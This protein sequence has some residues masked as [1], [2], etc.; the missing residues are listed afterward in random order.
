MHPQTQLQM[1]PQPKKQ[2]QIMQ[3]ELKTATQPQAMKTPSTLASMATTRVAKVET[4]TG[5][6]GNSATQIGMQLKYPTIQS[7][8]TIQSVLKSIKKCRSISYLHLL[9]INFHILF[10]YIRIAH[11]NPIDSPDQI[12][13]KEEE[14]QDINVEDEKEEQDIQ[15]ESKAEYLIVYKCI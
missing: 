11:N 10:G 1:Q 6:D 14:I 4:A 8:I 2:P 13:V 9:W 15:E 12:E 7:A 3:E 5:K